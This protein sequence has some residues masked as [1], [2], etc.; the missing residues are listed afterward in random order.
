MVF[1]IQN[2]QNR[3]ARAINLNLNE[4]IRAVGKDTRSDDRHRETQRSRTGSAYGQIR[5]IK[6]ECIESE[7]EEPVTDM[8]RFKK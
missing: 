4:L 7:K 8:S 5:E 3:D 6:A 2:T 1:L